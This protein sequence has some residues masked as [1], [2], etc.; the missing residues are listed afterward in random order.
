MPIV[1]SR[2][3][4]VAVGRSGL[5][6]EV[7]LSIFANS[8]FGRFAKF[9]FPTGLGLSFKLESMLVRELIRELLVRERVVE[10][11]DE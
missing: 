9:G 7:V 3:L 8:F 4:L 2:C 10:H 6:V 5:L 1:S 11:H